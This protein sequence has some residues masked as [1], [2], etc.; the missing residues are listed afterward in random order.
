VSGTHL[1]RPFATNEAPA[2]RRRRYFV[3]LRQHD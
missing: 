3:G 1:G 2:D